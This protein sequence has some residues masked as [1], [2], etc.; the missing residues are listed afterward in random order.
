MIITFDANVPVEAREGLTL[1]AKRSLTTWLKV[2]RVDTAKPDADP[3]RQ[4]IKPCDKISYG[5]EFSE[6]DCVH[7]TVIEQ[8]TYVKSTDPNLDPRIVSDAF[9]VLFDF[10]GTA[11]FDQGQWL[12]AAF[13]RLWSVYDSVST[14][15]SKVCCGLSFEEI[16]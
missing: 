1:V 12:V 9:E 13:D 3:Y 10:E 16:T 7:V 2:K 15:P 8:G 5:L 4:S 6:G 11:Y 14:D